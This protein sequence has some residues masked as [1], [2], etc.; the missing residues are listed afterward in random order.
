MRREAEE[1]QRKRAREDKGRIG[2]LIREGEDEE[3][4]KMEEDDDDDR[5]RMGRQGMGMGGDGQSKVVQEAR[6]LM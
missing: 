6:K 4:E 3:D 2:N 1:N 5:D